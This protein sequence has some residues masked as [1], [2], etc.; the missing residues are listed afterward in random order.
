MLLVALSLTAVYLMCEH[1]L[2]IRRGEL[3]P[4]GLE[5]D[6]HELLMAGQ[7][8]A[9]EKKCREEPSFLSF[10]LLHGISEIDDGWTAIEKALEDATSEQAARLLF[11]SL[12]GCFASLGL[13][14]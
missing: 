7:V 9:A 1:F 5:R 12:N 4:E 13:T 14:I 6:V 8:S 3:M 2:T 10:V 11:N